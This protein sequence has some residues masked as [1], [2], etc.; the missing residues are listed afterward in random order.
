MKLIFIEGPGKKPS[1]EKYAGKEYRVIPT[2]GHIRDLPV[3]GL[4][5]DI[6]KNF[7]P[8]YQILPDKK[9]VVENMIEQAKAEASASKA[10]TNNAYTSAIQQLIAQLMIDSK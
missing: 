10:Q 3:R 7:E 8:N 5:V 2:L 6:T 9:K 4:N 1:I